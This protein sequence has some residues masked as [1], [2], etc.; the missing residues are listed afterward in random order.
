MARRGAGVTLPHFFSLSLMSCDVMCND[1]KGIEKGV[2][3]GA[4][5]RSG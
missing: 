4:G 3:T 5:L 2:E 1:S